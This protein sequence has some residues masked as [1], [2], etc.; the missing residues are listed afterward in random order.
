ML[1][2]LSTES[3][4]AIAFTPAQT[5][6]VTR[7]IDALRK[8]IELQGGWIPFSDFMRFSLYEPG[9]GYYAAGALKFGPAGDFTTAPTLTPLFAH[10][11]ARSILPILR[12]VAPEILELGAGTGVMARDILAALSAQ[13]CQARYTILEV[14]PQLRAVQAE[15]LATLAPQVRWISELPEEINGV[16]LANEVLDA[17]PCE[18]IYF[19]KDQHR[20]VGVVMRDGQF[21][22]KTLTLL[23]NEL[24]ALERAQLR[25]PRIEGYVSEVNIEAEALVHTVTERMHHAVA[26]WID[27]GFPQREY[28]LDQRNQGTLMCHIQHRAHSDPFF[29]PGMQDVTSHVDFTAMAMAARDGGATQI[30]YASQAQ[31][32]LESGL[33]ESLVK[34]GE[35]G[36]G[37]YLAATNAVNTLVSPAEMGELFKVLMVTRGKCPATPG[38]GRDQSFRL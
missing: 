5:T 24:P 18:R 6:Q 31:W 30:A 33:L 35:P 15:T 4:A 23:K 16:V 34:V 17:V 8:R 27:Y 26:L 36:S 10:T 20:R 13:G 21:V 19:S 38:F 32:L 2:R 29:A 9:L 1:P 28:Y 14:S 11:I 12:G 22:F 37:Q 25:V 3:A 7:V